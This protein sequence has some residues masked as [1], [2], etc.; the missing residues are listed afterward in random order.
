MQLIRENMLLILSLTIYKND[1]DNFK[2]NIVF[3]LFFNFFILFITNIIALF[4]DDI[5]LIIILYGG[6][7]S[8][9]I[10]YIIPTI[11]YWMMISKNSVVLWLAGL[12]DFVII[13]LGISALVLKIIS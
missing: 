10:N 8:T 3:A 5:S 7:F 13:S 11:M 2:I 9:I 4:I 1:G 6:I 12:I